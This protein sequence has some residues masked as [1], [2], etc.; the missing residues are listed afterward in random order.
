[1]FRAS[2]TG[3]DYNSDDMHRF[4]MSRSPDEENTFTVTWMRR[5]MKE[6]K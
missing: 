1:M 3:G 6:N 5:Q 4:F 2:Q